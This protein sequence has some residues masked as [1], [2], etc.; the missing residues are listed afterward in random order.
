MADALETAGLWTIKEYIQQT[1]ANIV[2]QV[3]FRSIYE[4]CT[5]EERI[6]GDIRFM[7]WWDQDVGREVKR[8]VYECIFLKLIM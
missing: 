6:P 8:P 3:V 7:R 1:Q 2:A 5:R 4:I